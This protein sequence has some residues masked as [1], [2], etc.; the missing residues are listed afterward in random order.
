MLAASFA[1]PNGQLSLCSPFFAV[2]FDKLPLPL[3][4]IDHLFLNGLHKA[5][6]RGE[7]RLNVFHVSVPCR[8]PGQPASNAGTKKKVHDKDREDLH[9][10]SELS[11]LLPLMN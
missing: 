7:C 10:D 11:F 5:S 6:M 2:L 4:E 8:P 3:F 9:N 1:F